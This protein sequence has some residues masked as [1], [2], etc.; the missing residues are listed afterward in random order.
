MDLYEQA[1]ELNQKFTVAYNNVSYLHL[2][3]AER[4]LDDCQM[5]SGAERGDLMGSATMH[6]EQAEK[7][8]QEAIRTE[9]TF[10][11]AYDNKG[12]IAVN[13]A[14]L[15][16]TSTESELRGAVE[17][18]HEALSYQPSYREAYSDLANT[19][20]QLFGILNGTC[21]LAVPPR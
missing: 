19:H 1:I 3:R 14:R 17:C 6:L 12:N 5:K 16:L 7:W 18:F 2:K 20:S 13:R 10:H 8:C 9:R 4:V 21:S 11:M 15:E